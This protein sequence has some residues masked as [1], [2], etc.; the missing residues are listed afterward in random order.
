MKANFSVKK[1]V[2]DVCDCLQ[3]SE[4][5]FANNAGMSLKTLRDACNGKFTNKTLEKI[6]SSIYE[7]GIRLNAAKVELLEEQTQPGHTL[8][9]HG[10]KGGIDCLSENGSRP[11]CDFGPG[12]YCSQLYSSALCFIETY[13]Y[14]SIYVLD[15]DLDGLSCAHIPPSLDWMIIVCYFRQMLNKYEVHPVLKSSLEKIRGKDVIIAPIADNRMF[16]IMREFGEGNITDVEAIHA[17]SASRLGHQYVFKSKKALERIVFSDR[18]FCSSKERQNSA[19]NTLERKSAIDTKL[20][21]A[22][23]EFRGKGV[24]VDE[25]FK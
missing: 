3:I 6:Y 2:E 13:D 7:A 8:L 11:N 14:S 25:V 12:F 1:D 9:F 21:L 15:I 24:Y 19:R 10:S 16:Q 23:R 5:E 18:F 20:F 22:K 4:T 17:L